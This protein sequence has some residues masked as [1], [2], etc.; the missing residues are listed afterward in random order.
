MSSKRRGRTYKTSRRMRNRR[1]M[2]R[3][4]QF[5]IK[6]VVF[7]LLLA[8]LILGAVLGIKSCMSD[9]KSASKGQIGKNGDTEVNQKADGDGK[10][11]D[12]AE[13]GDNAGADG[14][15]EKEEQK[16]IYPEK[17][18]DYEDIISAEILSPYIAV[19]NVTDNTIVAGRSS[20]VRIYP[21]SMTKVMTLIV[22]V[23][24]VENLD[25]K[26]TMTSEIIDPLYRDDASRAGFEPGE[27][28]TALDMMYGL[29]L[30][31][32]ADA[33]VGLAQMISGSEEEFVQLMNQ[34]CE[35]LGLVNTHFTNTSGLH[36]EDHYTTPVEMAMILEYAMQNE[37]C[38]QILS[39]Y[40]YTT[41]PTEKHPE[42]ILLTSTM[43]SRMYGNEVAG[44]TI[45]AGKTGYT[46]EAKQC[47]VSYA[48]SAGKGYVIV[49][50]GADGKWN[51][52]YDDFKLY[53]QYCEGAVQEESEESEES[54]GEETS[55]EQ[56]QE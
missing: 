4:I 6:W 5:L 43:F 56:N 30:P 12:G 10:D 39:T 7:I 24:N 21:A 8:G 13:S 3:K 53:G 31:S 44:V 37:T 51:C 54:V 18:A 16:L 1:R 38:A 9:K 14:E 34:K 50:A 33:A 42:G 20:D 15:S 17:A 27:E 49:T 25:A 35:A 45:K 40:Q 28:I 47:L 36:G 48:E 22:A 26:F 11:G 2:K 46:Q 52:I 41:Q 29:I 55:G 32:G 19:V 23:E